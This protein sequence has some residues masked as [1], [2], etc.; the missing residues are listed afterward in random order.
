MFSQ[1]DKVSFKD[2]DGYCQWFAQTNNICGP[3]F[4]STNDFQA[5]DTFT[6]NNEWGSMTET[7]RE[8]DGRVSNIPCEFLEITFRQLEAI[9]APCVICFDPADQMVEGYSLCDYHAGLMQ[10][11]YTYSQLLTVFDYEF[12]AE[13]TPVLYPIVG[14][15]STCDED[16]QPII[17]DEVDT[18]LLD[19]LTGEG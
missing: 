1:G 3:N 10:K 4:S 8:R 14:V 18:L 12:Q 17:V 13:A 11:G 9:D 6:I 2:F 15:E 7:T 16:T 5:S 19:D